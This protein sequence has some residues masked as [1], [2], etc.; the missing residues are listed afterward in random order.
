M[1]LCIFTLSFIA[2]LPCL[3]AFWHAIAT[4]FYNLFIQ[5][6]HVCCNYN[7]QVFMFCLTKLGIFNS[8]YTITSR[9]TIMIN[10]V[11]KECQVKYH[12]LCEGE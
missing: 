9:V 6:I 5:I 2:S 7:Y 8:Y 4:S 12:T 11:Y 3:H 10:C 1:G